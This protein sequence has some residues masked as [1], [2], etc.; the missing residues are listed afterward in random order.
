MRK[1]LAY[2]IIGITTFLFLGWLFQDIY[3]YFIISIVLASILKPLNQYLQRTK[4]FGVKLPRFVSVLLSFLALFLVVQIF[5][6]LFLPL[7]SEQING[8]RS[9]NYQT[10]IELF[11]DPVHGFE[12]FLIKN[13]L[14]SREAGFIMADLRNNTVNFIREFDFSAM[15]NDVIVYTGSFV[16]GV[17]AVGFITFFLLYELGSLRRKIIRLI[18]NE[19]FEVSISAYTKI[20][21]LLS[22]YL[23]GLLFQMAAIFAIASIGLSIFGIEYAATIAL[24]AAI[25]NLIPYLGPILGATFGII[26]S[27]I[28]VGVSPGAEQQNIVMVFEIL[29]VFAIVQ[30]I[31]NI[32]LQ[33][34]IFSKSVKV[35]PLEIFVIIFA[36]ARLAGIPGMIL[37]IPVYTIIRVSAKEMYSGFKQYQIFK[38]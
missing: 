32:L 15:I 25:A 28:G 16:V 10:V 6:L 1:A 27:L 14:T 21:Q 17:M 24:F 4:F 20:E 13:K 7:I 31:D 23:V 2:L 11:Q 33:P 18:P 34:I 36:A 38:T 30:L 3:I 19:F 35:H 5:S 37:A 29:S 26:V 8:L 22:N 12:Q 9:I